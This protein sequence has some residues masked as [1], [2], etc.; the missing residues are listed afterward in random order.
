VTGTGL[1]RRIDG[2]TVETTSADLLEAL[3]LSW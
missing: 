2:R 3:N 1:A